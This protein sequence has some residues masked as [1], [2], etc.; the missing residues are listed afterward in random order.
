MKHG[1]KYF[2][3]LNDSNPLRCFWKTHI[4][5]AYS[6]EFHIETE[7][8]EQILGILAQNGIPTSRPNL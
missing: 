8:R 3:L 5:D 7:D 1:F 4:S 6:G 2:K